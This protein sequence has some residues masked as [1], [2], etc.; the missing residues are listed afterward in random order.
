MKKILTTLLCGLLLTSALFMSACNGTGE[1]QDT[2]APTEVA[3]EAPTEAPTEGPETN[4]DGNEIYPTLGGQT[5]AQLIA[6]LEAIFGTNYEAMNQM[7]FSMSMNIEGMNMSIDMEEE[8]LVK[9]DGNNVYTKTEGSD[10]TGGTTTTELWY[11]D[12]MIYTE[13]YDESLRPIKVCYE[14]S[15]DNVTEGGWFDMEDTVLMATPEA[16]LKDVTFVKIDDL[17]VVTISADKREIQRYA[18]VLDLED[19]GDGAEVSR[20]VQ[21]Y[22]FNADGSLA[23]VTYDIDMAMEGMECVVVNK[24]TVTGMGETEVKAPANASEYMYWDGE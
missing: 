21:T 8:I 24:C 23:Y 3:T 6:G 7:T 10:G 20:L 19:L 22:Y 16:W 18:D 14:V 12:G 13:E 1:P 4:A 2:E 5:P 17:Y 9:R 15:Y 11:V